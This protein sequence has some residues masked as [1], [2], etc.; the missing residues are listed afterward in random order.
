MNSTGDL[1]GLLV[2][3][4]FDDMVG[5][6]PDHASRSTT[7]SLPVGRPLLKSCEFVGMSS[8]RDLGFAV[9]E[10]SPPKRAMERCGICLGLGFDLHL[11]ASRQS[12]EQVGCLGAAVAVVGRPVGLLPFAGF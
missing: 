6:M 10:H 2:A 9:D 4:Y 3:P 8:C 7:S 1:H 5:C 12:C 11:L